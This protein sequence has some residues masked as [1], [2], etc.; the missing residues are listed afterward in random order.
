VLELDAA[1]LDVEV[2]GM[3]EGTTVPLPDFS[4]A[5]VGIFAM[6]TIGLAPQPPGAANGRVIVVP[7]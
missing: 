7:A 6:H 1:P 4:R 5:V 3:E 2:L